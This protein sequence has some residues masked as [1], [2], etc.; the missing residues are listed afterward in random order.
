[1]NHFFY[2]ESVASQVKGINIFGVTEF[3][4]NGSIFKAHPCYKND[5]SWFDWVL[6]AWNVESDKSETNEDDCPDFID[7]IGSEK[8]MLIPAKI[9]VL[10]TDEKNDTYAIIHS[11]LQ[12]CKKISVLT[13]RWQ[14]EYENEKAMKD[15]QAHYNKN[16]SSSILTPVYHKVS[17]NTI[18]KHCLIIPYKEDSHFVMEIIEQH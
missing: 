11:C 14:M 15:S 13:Y 6:I 1:M 12:Y 16:E 5:L 7:L 9:I 3:S 8:A 18:Q 10:I 4:F 2:N 17:V